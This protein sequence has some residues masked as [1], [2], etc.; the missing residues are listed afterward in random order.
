LPP[1]G[2]Q[3]P[4]TPG[5][6]E[7]VSGISVVVEPPAGNRAVIALPPGAPNAGGFGGY[8]LTPGAPPPPGFPAAVPMLA[9]S[10]EDRDFDTKSLE[11]VARLKDLPDQAARKTAITELTDLVTNQFNTRQKQREQEL[12]Q[13]EEQLKKLRSIQ[14]RREAAR[15][16]IITDRVRQLMK[17]AEGL[18]W[19]AATGAVPARVYSV[20]HVNAWA[21]RT[22]TITTEPQTAPVPKPQP[23]SGVVRY[24]EAGKGLA[25]EIRFFTI[26]NADGAKGAEELVGVIDSLL[27][28][29]PQRPHITVTSFGNK[30]I[31]K[32][33]PDA[34]KQV[35]I[36]IQQLQEDPQPGKSAPDNRDKK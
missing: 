34:V 33:S 24:T 9:Q 27:G 17:E 32:G 15:D 10:S 2:V 16:E 11:L 6:V 3:P 12:K 14:E 26:A 21:Q 35:E 19:G 4:A 8:P 7:K 36:L 5:I 31:C 30:I 20:E 13:L 25:D 22:P 23:N 28:K 18:N 29:G 1:T